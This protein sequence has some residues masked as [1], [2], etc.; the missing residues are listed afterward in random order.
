[1]KPIALVTLL[2]SFYLSLSFAADSAQIA[3]WELA[4]QKFLNNPTIEIYFLEIDGDEVSFNYDVEDPDYP[5]D[6]TYECVGIG[7]VE[8][9]QPSF[10]SLECEEEEP[11]LWDE[12]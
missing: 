12:L 4:A 3:Q 6:I 7:K 11:I 5:A 9:A 2:S 10:V 8:N 1:M